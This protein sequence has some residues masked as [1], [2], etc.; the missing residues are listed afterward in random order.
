MSVQHYHQL[1]RRHR[2]R[3]VEI[4]TRNGAVYRGIIEDVNERKVYLREVKSGNLGGFGYG[5]YRPYYGYGR[6]PY[7]VA[8]GFGFGFGIALG[9]ITGLALLPFFFW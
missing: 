3:A 8:R 2:G 6:R 7:P 9:A 4:R 5:F 1:C